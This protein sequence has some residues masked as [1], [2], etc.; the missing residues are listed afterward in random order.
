MPRRAIRR[1]R[2]AAR[3]LPRGLATHSGRS[4]GGKR[5]VHIW[6]SYEAIIE[7]SAP[8]TLPHET[9]KLLPP[10]GVPPDDGD[11]QVEAGT[12][13]KVGVGHSK[14]ASGLQQVA[15]GF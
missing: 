12:I 7:A 6:A 9:Q 10:L 13:G 14:V 2:R 4:H 15:P 5:I 8:T 3:C 1:S 11:C